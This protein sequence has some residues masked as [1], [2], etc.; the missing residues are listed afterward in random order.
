[1]RLAGEFL[2]LLGVHRLDDLHNMI[3][4]RRVDAT[5]SE[6]C[7]NLLM[8]NISPFNTEAAEFLNK[9]I[10][11][12]SKY[13]MPHRCRDHILSVV[14]L[15]CF[16]HPMFTY[17]LPF[18]YCSVQ[19]KIGKTG[20]LNYNKSMRPS[21]YSVGFGLTRP[22]FKFSFSHETHRVN[23]DQSCSVSLTSLAAV[24]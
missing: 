12:F 23:L 5:K 1:M 15:P 13:V 16:I 2:L 7:M 9:F 3:K 24:L 19:K 6:T 14:L 17:Q 10:L 22:R 18:F 21:C 11:H 4:T 20:Y 8:E